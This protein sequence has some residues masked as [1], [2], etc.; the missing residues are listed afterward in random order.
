MATNGKEIKGKEGKEIKEIRE[1]K[2]PILEQIDTNINNVIRPILTGLKIEIKNNV[3]NCYREIEEKKRKARKLI[4]LLESLKLLLNPSGNI[5]G[6]Q[7]DYANILKQK[8]K[9]VK[10]FNKFYKNSMISK[11]SFSYLLDFNKIWENN[12]I[13]PTPAFK[14]IDTKNITDETITQIDY[15]IHS[16]LYYILYFEK[17]LFEKIE[18]KYKDKYIKKSDDVDYNTKERKAEESLK[19]FYD[20][21]SNSI[22]MGTRDN[23][24]K[25][26]RSSKEYDDL[27]LNLKND[28]INLSRKFE[29]EK[30]KVKLS[31]N[32]DIRTTELVN[33]INSSTITQKQKQKEVND[34]NKK[35]RFKIFNYIIEEYYHELKYKRSQ[36]YQDLQNSY[37]RSKFKGKMKR[38]K[39]FAKTSIA[40]VGSQYESKVH[41]GKK[42]KISP[43]LGFKINPVK[44]TQGSSLNPFE[45]PF[46]MFSYEELA[47][48]ADRLRES[49]NT[50][51]ASLQE[52]STPLE[53]SKYKDVKYRDLDYYEIKI[54]LKKEIR[55][56]KIIKY[57]LLPKTIR[58]R[59]NKTKLGFGRKILID[60]VKSLKSRLTYRSPSLYTDISKKQELTSLL[61]TN[62]DSISGVDTIIEYIKKD[63]SKL[64]KILKYKKT[65]KRLKKYKKMLTAQQKVN[66]LDGIIKNYNTK[67]KENSKKIKNKIITNLNEESSKRLKLKQLVE[68]DLIKLAE[69]KPISEKKRIPGKKNQVIRGGKIII[70][71]PNMFEDIE[72]IISYKDIEWNKFIDT[73]YEHNMTECVKATDNRYVITA[74]FNHSAVDI[75][76]NELENWNKNK[77]KL[78]PDSIPFV[79][80][81]DDINKI[82]KDANEKKA[83]TFPNLDLNK[84]C[85]Y[86]A[87]YTEK[88][89]ESYTDIKKID[90]KNTT[91]LDLN[92]ENTVYNCMFVNLPNNCKGITNEDVFKYI[93]TYINQIKDKY[94]DDILVL[95]DF[96]CTLTIKN[97]SDDL[98]DKDK[99]KIYRSKQ[100]NTIISQYIGDKEKIEK[101]RKLLND[102]KY[103]SPDEIEKINKNAASV[104]EKEDDAIRK[105]APK[106]LKIIIL[107]NNNSNEN[108]SGEAMSNII[109]SKFKW[110]KYI[111]YFSLN[112]LYDIYTKNTPTDLVYTK[113]EKTQTLGFNI[114]STPVQ[115]LSDI[116]SKELKE[117][118][119]LVYIDDDN[120]I[121]Q[122]YKPQF[123]DCTNYI[124]NGKM[125]VYLAK[126]T[127]TTDNIT[128]LINHINITDK[129]LTKQNI[130][131]SNCLLISLPK[132]SK[133]I[134]DDNFYDQIKTYLTEIQK[135][136]VNNIVFLCDFNGTLTNKKIEESEFPTLNTNID[137]INTY[138][139]DEQK[140]K[141]EDLF[142]IIIPGKRGKV[143]GGPI[144]SKNKQVKV[145]VSSKL[146]LANID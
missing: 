102:I 6:V 64:G 24:P 122:Q 141:I 8:G 118:T 13:K 89:I 93:Q 136:Y 16:Y 50:L 2:E 36:T 38:L 41:L 34:F 40:F 131:D 84:I 119:F 107:E 105:A 128:N 11:L 23:K 137:I 65:L 117:F 80:Y 74:N 91:N 27:I 70:R 79:V 7:K 53:N 121:M 109:I 120:K 49:I 43:I 56:L 76:N 52:H 77:Y 125:C 124:D 75:I 20:Y 60:N 108:I 73:I 3:Q 145:I 92:N 15:L 47:E 54:R 146:S 55:K 116:L 33:K 90:T 126:Y 71:T 12:V 130:K 104:E 123:S 96:D 85:I 67:N 57:F 86:I 135:E 115:R 19:K 87:K 66:E 10:K 32:I 72:D 28:F 39:S 129:T 45:N 133:G 22:I 113:K 103:L 94:R 112:R 142:D 18:I 69:S 98:N 58:T 68:T 127:N 140:N 97:L 78:K 99:T 88:K 31:E 37:E 25:I 143:P 26:D 61:K 30:N 14:N 111:N 83:N 106:S 81:I 17:N 114:S 110:Q 46:K 5:D 63:G 82:I 62:L 144:N 139:T 4:Y 1:N 134:T 21:V 101:I 29:K 138:I 9:I 132:N 51:N 59:K 95:F 35:Y 100:I 42:F 44:A 48:F